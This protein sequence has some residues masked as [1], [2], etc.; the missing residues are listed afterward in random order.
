MIDTKNK[1]PLWTPA[2]ILLL[3]IGTFTSISFNMINPII[4]K[5]AI[6]LGSTLSLAGIVAGLFSI[7]ALTARPAG[8]VIVDRMNKKTVLMVSTIVMAIASFGYA[9]SSNIVMLVIS[10]LVHGIAFAVSG[11]VTTALIA[12]AVPRERLGEG[13]GYFGLGYIIAMAIGPNIGIY[14]VDN[15][16]YTINFIISGT[17]LFLAT[18]LIAKIP[19]TWKAPD[20]SAFKK[21]ITIDDLISI[22]LLP[23]AFVGGIFSFTN[24]IVSSFLVLIGEERGIANIGLY[25][26]VLA[27]GYFL[28]RPFIGKLYDRK[29]LSIILYPAFL[30]V[31]LESLLLSQAS[32]LWIVLLAAVVKALGQG[33]AQPTIQSTCLKKLDPAKSGVAAATYFIGA[34]IGQGVGPM[35]GGKIAESFGYSAMFFFCVGLLVLGLIG[36][37]FYDIYDRKQNKSMS[38]EI[39]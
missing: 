18:F 12:S 20:K 38:A 7:T 37:I 14:F 32:V 26:T 15:L 19:F 13:I 2:F 10:R 34:D 23:L 39:P 17:A 5:Y 9:A 6:Q 25:F 3:F 21:K 30:L 36:Y 24:G 16:G 11:T 27:I 33:A 22:K 31:M 28:T 4:S 35:V 8:A 1:N 29:G